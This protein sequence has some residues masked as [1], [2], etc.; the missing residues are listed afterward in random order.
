[1]L[2]IP[3]IETNM[4]ILISVNG[5]VMPRIEVNEF[6]VIEPTFL[7]MESG[8]VNRIIT[9]EELYAMKDTLNLRSTMRKFWIA[10]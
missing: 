6:G 9:E 3:I 8:C 10:N 7:V 1:M 5:G 2:I 4:D